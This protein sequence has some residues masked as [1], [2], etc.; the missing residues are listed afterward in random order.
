MELQGKRIVFLGDSITEGCGT[1]A[2]EHIYWNVIGRQTGAEVYAD[3]IGG[4]RIA[5]QQVP[6]VERPWEDKYFASR[7]DDLPDEADVVVVFGGTNDFGHGDAAF[8]KM[9]DRT[10]DTFYGACH[11]LMLKL[12]NKYPAAQIVA[13][14]PL[15][16]L[17]ED[18]TA[19]NESGVR[20][21]GSLSR[22]V[23]AV[24]E[25]AAFYGIP[26][27][28]LYR[29]SGMQPRVEIL[30]ERYMPDGLHPN[31]AGHLLIVRRLLGL[32]NTL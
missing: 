10:P 3:G 19:Y 5:R 12:I 16:R 24:A 14:T 1:S 31:D 9:E 2:K 7:V 28:D 15:H 23:D 13:M 17:S 6:T 18:E 29:T 22:Y 26:V 20:R 30:R 32:L 25:V 27:V 11:E 4:T 8:G 21:M